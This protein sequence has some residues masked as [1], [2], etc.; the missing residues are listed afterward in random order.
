MSDRG[1]EHQGGPSPPTPYPSV[2]LDGVHV[3]T[4]PTR[5]LGRS[6]IKRCTPTS[7]RPD[8]KPLII[9]VGIGPVGARIDGRPKNRI[10]R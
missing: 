4:T 5:S 1:A 10:A 8:M 7:I 6:A 9:D 2:H 3:S